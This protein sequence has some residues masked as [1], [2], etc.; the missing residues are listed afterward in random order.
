MSSLEPHNDASI[1]DFKAQ[2]A[3]ALQFVI[4]RPMST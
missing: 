2:T 1:S 3:F 4:K